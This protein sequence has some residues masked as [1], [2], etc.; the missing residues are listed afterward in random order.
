MTGQYYDVGYAE[1][2]LLSLFDGET[3][4]AEAMA[5]VS[6]SNRDLALSLAEVTE[7]IR[8]AASVDLIPTGPKPE[9]PP[10]LLG[11]IAAIN[12]LWMKVSLPSPERILD[13]LWPV[14]GWTQSRAMAFPL[15]IVVVGAGIVGMSH[16]SEI[17]RAFSGILAVGNWLPLAVSWT[18]L[19]IW[20]ELGHALACRRYGVSVRRCG[21]VFILLA[22]CPF[23]DATEAWSLRSRWARVHIAAAGMIAE[24]AVAALLIL[25][26]P[27][28][29]GGGD[30]WVRQLVANTLFSATVATVLFNANPL[31]KFDGYYMLSD[32][33]RLPNLATR[34]SA[35]VRARCAQLVYGESIRVREPVVVETYGYLAAAWRVVVTV[36]LMAA[37]TVLLPGVGLWIGLAGAIASFVGPVVM[38]LRSALERAAS[39]RLGVRPFVVVPVMGVLFAATLVQDWPF[40]VSVPGVVVTKDRLAVRAETDGFVT[41][42]VAH[43]ET[44]VSVSDL[45]YRID[46]DE[47]RTRRDELLAQIDQSIA[48][49]RMQDADGRL[50]DAQV[51]ADNRTRLRRQLAIVEDQLEHCDVGPPSGGRYVAMRDPAETVGTYVSEGDELGAM[52][53]PDG[54][55]VQAAVS[56]HE[57]DHFRGLEGEPVSIRLPAGDAVGATIKRVAPAA[58]T[59][60]IDET[61][62]TTV[63]GPIAVSAAVSDS[64]KTVEPHFAMTIS[65]GDA[66]APSLTSRT[67]PGMRVAVEK[68]SNKS[69]ARTVWEASCRWWEGLVERERVAK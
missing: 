55:E 38:S 30:V 28:L 47:T 42:A 66:D 23:V 36:S 25:A 4:V 19:K 65:I 68:R 33:A 5:I 51:E 9:K 29:T 44:D 57:I 16:A 7:L 49:Q 34:A 62:L 52:L 48:R 54:L 1:Y 13:V 60:P 35:V 3:T 58:T 63:G 53:T 22:P 27:L 11:T 18:V 2:V 8:W 32:M 14:L 40:P 59:T 64:P 31:M 45:L 61:L 67:L 41:W 15:A 12:P 10:S 50:A 6:R 21:V 20:H 17:E 24:L 39:G 26:W 56:H 46:N 37:A 69:T 43:V